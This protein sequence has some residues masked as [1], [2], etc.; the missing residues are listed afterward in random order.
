MRQPLRWT[1]PPWKALFPSA[2]ASVA[3]VLRCQLHL[4]GVQTTLT[5]TTL[6]LLLLLQTKEKRT[7][8]RW[9]S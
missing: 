8:T 1:L 6:R 5:L 4:E 2:R 7:T 9:R 3:E